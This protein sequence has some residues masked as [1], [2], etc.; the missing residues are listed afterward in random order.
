VTV[1]KFWSKI[2]KTEGC[3]LWTGVT[4]QGYGRAHLRGMKSAL[5]HR[6]AW[7]LTTGAP[8]PEGLCVCHHCDNPPCCNPSHLF[9]GTRG[10][11]NSDS[12]K[13]G[14][15]THGEEH[16]H[17]KLTAAQVLAIRAEYAA[18]PYYGHQKDLCKKYNTC[19]TEV[20]HILHRTIWKEL[21]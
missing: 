15:H 7:E 13:K 19:R 14:R 6:I 10:E 3:W 17:A 2:N 1:E 21:T 11:N 5:T 4:A 18:N 20:W 8:V 9:L 12:A 16:S